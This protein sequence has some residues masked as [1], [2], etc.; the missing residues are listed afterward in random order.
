MILRRMFLLLV[1]LAVPAAAQQSEPDAW[2]PGEGTVRL[3]HPHPETDGRV[4]ST[5]DLFSIAA[6]SYYQQNISRASVSRCPFDISCSRFAVTAIRRYGV[7]GYAM[8]IDRYFYRENAGA[9]SAYTRRIGPNGIVKLDDQ[10]FL[11]LFD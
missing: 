8:F 9:F 3:L 7:L 11:T 4:P 10:P 6:I 1:L 5:L 2:E